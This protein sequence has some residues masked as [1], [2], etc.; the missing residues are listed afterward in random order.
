ME[1]GWQIMFMIVLVG[2]MYSSYKLGFKE[3][4]GKMIDF[5]KTKSDKRGYTLI[6]FFGN[7]IEF[8]DPLSYNKMI[9]DAISD[10]IEEKDDSSS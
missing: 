6:H 3:G 10:T 9:L 4:T 8:I 7:Q 1:F 5:C 2:G